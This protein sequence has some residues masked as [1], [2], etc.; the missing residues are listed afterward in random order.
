MMRALIDHARNGTQPPAE[1]EPALPDSHFAVEPLKPRAA[2]VPMDPIADPTPP[3][4]V[5]AAAPERQRQPKAGAV[6]CTGTYPAEL[7][8]AGQL[9][10]PADVQDILGGRPRTLY[11]VPSEQY[12][13]KEDQLQPDSDRLIVCTPAGLAALASRQ[14]GQGDD[15]AWLA[16]RWYS[17]VVR[18]EVSVAGRLV[19]PQ[20]MLKDA[21]LGSNVLLI[22]AGDG[23]EL[24][25]AER[26]SKEFR[27]DAAEECE[28]EP[29]DLSLEGLLDVLNKVLD[30]VAEGLSVSVS[31]YSDDPNVRM[32]ELLNT[33]DD[34]GAIE[35]EWES[36]WLNDPIREPQRIH[37]GIQ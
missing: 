12:V 32:Q 19:V 25:N 31:I 2:D 7:D 22:G 36:I 4:A 9:Q 11:L 20:E 29:S 1:P 21:A 35:T 8:A 33:S 3:V 13:W 5:T 18:V 34:L 23:Y 37:G 17:K 26:W 16:R 6:P 15:N 27:P 28:P 24:W 14:R 30:H 10:L